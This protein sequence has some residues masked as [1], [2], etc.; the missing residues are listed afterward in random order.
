MLTDEF[1]L[2]QDSVKYATIPLSMLDAP[3]RE[4]VESLLKAQEE[5]K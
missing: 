1:V 4:L 2:F 3:T 5:E